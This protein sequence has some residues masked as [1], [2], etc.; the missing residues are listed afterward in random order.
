MTK[1]VGRGADVVL[2]ADAMALEERLTA[3][4]HL[5]AGRHRRRGNRL[6]ECCVRQRDGE[7]Q[8][9][10]SYVVLHR[11]PSCVRTV[12]G[13]LGLQACL[14]LLSSS[15][16]SARFTRGPPPPPL[17]ECECPLHCGPAPARC[18]PHP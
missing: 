15:P 7:S 9:E 12:I 16:C 8:T 2:R 11:F 14:H 4:G 10:G 17:L 13:C 6:S 5:E 3:V 1:L 18:A